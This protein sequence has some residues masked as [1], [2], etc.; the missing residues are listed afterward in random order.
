[1]Y[2]NID[3]LAPLALEELNKITQAIQGFSPQ[4][5]LW[6]SGYLAGDLA[7]VLA[8][9]LAGNSGAQD[10]STKN[11][12]IPQQQL[13]ILYGSQ[14]GNCRLLAENYAQASHAKSINSKV[15]SLADFKPRQIVKEKNIVLI[16][17]THGE[18]EAPDD[19]QI[20]YDYLFSNK[21]LQL[22]SLKYSILALG[23]SSYEKYCQTG[24]DLD[25]QL[26]KLGAQSVIDRVDCDL[27]YEDLAD[28]WQQ[29]TVEYFAKDLVDSDYKT[30]PLSLLKSQSVITYNRNNTYVSEI[31][32]IQKITTIDSVKNVYHIELDMQDSNITY[33][34]GDSLGIVTNNNK[35]IVDKF[36]KTHKFDTNITVSYKKNNI[37]FEQ[38]LLSLEISL[39]NK[40]FLKFY[41]Q[42]IQSEAL[43]KITDNHQRFLKY[44]SQRQLSD[45]FKEYPSQITEQYLVD[46]LVKITPRLYS[47]A[48]SYQSNDEEIHLTIALVES[49][50]HE[51]ANGLVSGLLCDQ[52]IEGDSV[53][54]YVESNQNFSLPQ[55]HK[56][57]IIMIG[58]G[59]G[60]A[61]FRGF[62]Q[63]RESTK[64][65][66]KNWLFFGNPSFDHDFLY[67]L[68]LQKFYENGTL[69][70]ID[71]A[72]SRDQH[73][74]IYVQDRV[75]QKAQKIWQ[76]LED[77]AHLYICG[78]KD[79]MAKAVEAELLSMIETYG[80]KNP[81]QAKSYLS[82]LKQNKRYQKDVY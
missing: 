12:N 57:P 54:I 16:V 51:P 74:K 64:A 73:E 8:D 14:T 27:D 29:Q 49:S 65:I 45:V 18:G 70:A 59:T 67:Q 41:A 55:D 58:A 3:P 31:L 80:G 1:M 71:L 66:G 43:K 76:W 19:A 20:F 47:I 44:V 60:I 75:K 82:D 30:A 2:S 50:I 26:Q 37:T 79:H 28:N 68:E 38:A 81:E 62:L 10:S 40:L 46:N 36:I 23:D 17:S 7:G 63:E 13:T 6:L 52:S 48:S 21:K 34:A 39:I 53:E 11:N 32:A 72:F 22:K 24:V 9:N 15:I 5:K 4:Q 33:Q 61:P 69:N 77:G 35:S 25:K 78:N 56:T 42:F